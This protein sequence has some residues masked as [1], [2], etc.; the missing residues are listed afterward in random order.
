MTNQCLQRNDTFRDLERTLATIAEEQRQ[1]LQLV[2]GFATN[3]SMS[4]QLNR[5][6]R[7]ATTESI[8][9][10]ARFNAT[11][12]MAMQELCLSII[13]FSSTNPRSH[14]ASK[15]EIP[16]DPGDALPKLRQLQDSLVQISYDQSYCKSA[17]ALAQEEAL[18]I[19]VFCWFQ[20]RPEE[21]D[22]YPTT[23]DRLAACLNGFFIPNVTCPAFESNEDMLRTTAEM[24]HATAREQLREYHIDLFAR[25]CTSSAKFTAA[26]LRD[27]KVRILPIRTATVVLTTGT[28]MLSR[29]RAQ[30][31]RQSCYPRATEQE[32]PSPGTSCTRDS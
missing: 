31:G 32:S 28:G 6:I 10:N 9:R 24:L 25:N 27:F 23:Y 7:I 21:T 1:L 8:R 29:I 30:T 26:E 4:H 14:R 19:Y 5:C 2:R 20:S 22:I 11:L 15:L 12:N 16:R 18:R 3:A 17:W 13:N